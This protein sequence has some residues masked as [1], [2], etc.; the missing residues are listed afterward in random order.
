MSPAFAAGGLLSR[1]WPYDNGQLHASARTHLLEAVKKL[2]A[3]N[4]KA[5]A[6]RVEAML[7]ADRHRDLSIE[8]SWAGPADL[9]LRDQGTDR[10]GL[11]VA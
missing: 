11:L 9:D 8:M 10:H 7:A 2:D 3:A 1:D 6:E 4:R 5:E